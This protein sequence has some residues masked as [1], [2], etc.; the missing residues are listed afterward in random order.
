MEAEFHKNRTDGRERKIGPRRQIPRQYS[1]RRR[2]AAAAVLGID[3]GAELQAI[4]RTAAST[5]PLMGL[6]SR[7]ANRNHDENANQQEQRAD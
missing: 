5:Y 2:I 4:E 1:Q 3:G 6:Q 7:T